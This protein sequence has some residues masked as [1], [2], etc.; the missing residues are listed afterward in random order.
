[1]ETNKIEKLKAEVQQAATEHL[2]AGDA[3]TALSYYSKN[4]AI[5]SNGYLYPAFQ[6]FSEHVR[7]FYA[8]LRK[9]DLAVWEDIHIPI[10]NA[11]AGIFTAK[12]RWRSTDTKGEML[13]LQGVWSAMFV[14]EKDCWKIN[15]R[16]ESFSP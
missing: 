10:I 4:A 15:T 12:F 13:N 5:V 2:N 7:E 6:L 14:R 1:M 11:G 8:S 3:D 9:V 16:H